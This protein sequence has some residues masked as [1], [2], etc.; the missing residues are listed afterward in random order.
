MVLER[1]PTRW[2]RGYF[3]ESLRNPHWRDDYYLLWQ[4]RRKALGLPYEI[5]EWS[6]P[7]G[8]RVS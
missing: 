1:Q 6:H 3:R 2:P 8:K 5:P 7:L 4:K